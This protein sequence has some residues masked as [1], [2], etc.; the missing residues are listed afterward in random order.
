MASPVRLGGSALGTPAAAQVLANRPCCAK[1]P[2]G[3]CSRSSRALA[4]QRRRPSGREG[5]L[6]PASTRR[7]RMDGC[8]DSQLH[9]GAYTRL[10]L[11]RHLPADGGDPA[12]YRG[13]EPETR[14]PDP[15]IEA[16]AVVEHADSQSRHVEFGVEHPPPR[17]G[18]VGWL[19]TA[20]ID[21]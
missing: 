4:P 5:L 2:P 16:A 13:A 8:R 9:V 12:A 3:R 14:L 21:V 1:A 18:G 11:D 20:P 10:R 6:A 7:A 19:G 15:V 17:G